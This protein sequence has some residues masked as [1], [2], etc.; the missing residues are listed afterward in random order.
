[1]KTLSEHSTVYGGDRPALLAPLPRLNSSRVLDVGCG[2]GGLA[3]HLREQGAAYI[4]G[5]EPRMDL[6]GVAAERL[7]DVFVG[8]VEEALASHLKESRWDLIVLADVLEHLVDPWA[9]MTGLGGL[10]SAGG[11]I[12][13]SVPNVSHQHVIGHLVKHGDWAYEDSGVFDRTHLRWFGR[14][15]LEE[16]IACSGATPQVW[17]GRVS[18]GFRR[19]RYARDV[20]DLSHWPAASIYQFLVLAKKL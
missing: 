15:S 7:D 11:M 10:L 12:L 18:V 16:L 2:S 4:A 20:I 17:S 14:K 9:A 8:T 13:V 19:L 6:A 1:M 3:P 5:I